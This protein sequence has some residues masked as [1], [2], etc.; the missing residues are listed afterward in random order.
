MSTITTDARGSTQAGPATSP[1]PHESTAA[2]V[3]E[4]RRALSAHVQTLTPHGSAVTALRASHD[5]VTAVELL[6]NLADAIFAFGE[7]AAPEGT[8]IDVRRPD[9]RR[10][11]RSELCGRPAAR[12]L[13]L[14]ACELSMVNGDIPPEGRGRSLLQ[15]AVLRMCRE[16]PQYFQRHEFFV[17]RALHGST[18]DAAEEARAFMRGKGPVDLASPHM[19]FSPSHKKFFKTHASG[20]AAKDVEQLLADPVEFLIKSQ[21]E[22]SKKRGETE[23]KAEVETLL[24]PPPADLAA[25]TC[26]LDLDD[27]ARIGS[28]NILGNNVFK[29]PR[30][31]KAIRLAQA[32]EREAADA[33]RHEEMKE[34]L[35]REEKEQKKADRAAAKRKGTGTP[36]GTG[37]D[38]ETSGAQAGGGA[39]QGDDNAE[40]GGGAAQGGAAA[41]NTPPSTPTGD[42]RDDDL[43]P[44]SGIARTHFDDDEKKAAELEAAEDND[45]ITDDDAA[46][47][48]SQRRARAVS[49]VA[50]L[51]RLVAS[52]RWTAVAI[53][54]VAV[55][56]VFADYARAEPLLS[57]WRWV[58]SPLTGVGV[59]NCPEASVF[60]YDPRVWMLAPVVGSVDGTTAVDVFPKERFDFERAPAALFLHSRVHERALAIVSVHL[61]PRGKKKGELSGADPLTGTRNEVRALE[62]VAAWLPSAAAARGCDPAS[63]TDVIVGDF[64]LAPPN[65]NERGDVD[66]PGDAW[67][68]VIGAGFVS[69]KADGTP[70]N[71]P[72]FTSYAAE[73]DNAIVRGAPV[74]SRAPRA[75]VVDTTGFTVLAADVAVVERALGAL[76]KQPSKREKG[77]LQHDAVIV[78]FAESMRASFIE[79]KKD[80]RLRFNA[81]FSDHK[82]ISLCIPLREG[83]DSDFTRARRAIETSAT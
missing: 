56:N 78:S 22:V 46:L 83:A 50:A 17:L 34:R 53:Q 28:W 10:V 4:A 44:I 7:A 41:D 82:P 26:A 11:G 19:Q 75:V 39:A 2:A 33:V 23:I 9:G 38:S 14:F 69:S 48:A 79:C 43:H 31:K 65:H 27:F 55:D 68:P 13:L 35:A 18:A 77:A 80:A 40:A 6:I 16:G 74:P 76:P 30:S 58:T 5:A 51:A 32:V 54:E 70:S 81:A 29:T 57:E 66:A 61:R 12:A 36:A 25:L 47:K 52:E 24:S 8:G 20:S 71:V 62:H 49:K 59:Q 73:Y 72:E 42:P 21:K 1:P 15:R 63:L 37:S 60:G 45:T 3:G 64:N 67:D